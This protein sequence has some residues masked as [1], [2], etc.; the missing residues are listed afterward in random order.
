MTASLPKTEL[1]HGGG[2]SMVC[3]KENMWKVE[4]S[5]NSFK[6]KSKKNTEELHWQGLQLFHSQNKTVNQA[7]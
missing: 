5:I 6:P 7:W 2:S 4:A 3:F 1:E